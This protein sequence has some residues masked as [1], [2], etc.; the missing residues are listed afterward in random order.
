[1]GVLFLAAV[2]GWTRWQSGRHRRGAGRGRREPQIEA[3]DPDVEL[4]LKPHPDDID[5]HEPVRLDGSR[6][7]RPP[8]HPDIE[9]CIISL[10][11]LAPRGEVLLGNDIK[12]AFQG[13]GLEF[14]QMDIYHRY[15]PGVHG[16]DAV[17]SVANLVEPGVF[18]PSTMATFSTPGLAMFLRLPGPV[19]GLTAFDDFI[20]TARL[21]ASRLGVEVLD[22]QRN[23]LSE[24]AIG[25]LREAV[26][27]HERRQRAAYAG[28]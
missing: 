9:E 4:G 17:F 23:L 8:A 6:A 28:A 24:Q 25:H 20:A 16:G 3:L 13:A 15:P 18:K 5:E 19:D 12:A 10:Y 2:Y 27:E 21:L 22:A 1:V 7:A 11:L 14:G 26:I